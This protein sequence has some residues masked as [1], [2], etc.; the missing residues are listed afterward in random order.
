MNAIKS[1]AV[2]AALLFVA[3][4]PLS[5]QVKWGPKIGVN[6]TNLSMDDNDV[7]T[8]DGGAGFTAGL[9]LEIMIPGSSIGFDASFMY[10]RVSSSLISTGAYWGAKG[11]KC[12]IDR[13][14]LE[15]PIALKWK[16]G[17]PAFGKVATP[18]LFTG[19]SVAFLCSKK[20]LYDDFV[21]CK[22]IRASWSFGIGVELIKMFQISASYSV[23]MTDA[24]FNNI[25]SFEGVKFPEFKGRENF[26]TVTA[27]YLF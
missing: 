7:F 6:Y 18:Y 1:L 26:W 5:S 19:P 2:T 12:G 17:V 15:I 13:D 10:S 3:T 4:L 14:Y 11:D 16:I 27:A 9:A 24:V 8:S 25:E 23:A 20:Y 21:E 22:T